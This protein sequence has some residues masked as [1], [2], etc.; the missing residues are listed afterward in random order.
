MLLKHQKSISQELNF[1]ALSD[2]EKRTEFWDTIRKVLAD[3]EATTGTKLLLEKRSL[4]LRNVMAPDVFSILNYFNPNCIEEIQFK[5][6]FRVA[7]PLYGIVDLPHWNH[8][9]D[10]TLHGF[11]IGNIAQNISHLEWFSADV[12]V[13]TAEDVLQ[14][15]NMMLRSGQLKMCKLYGYSNQNESFQQSLGP[16][17]TEEEFQEGIQE[18]TWKFNSSIP[19]NVL[20]VKCVG[21]TIVFEMT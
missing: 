6:E 10:V 4:T 18:Q 14:I 1:I 12:R 11:D 9:T 13:L 5:G 16:I 2:P 3:T 8:L 15:K 7:Q 19:G 21:P 20:E 17:F